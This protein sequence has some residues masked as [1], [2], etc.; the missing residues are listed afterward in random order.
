[1]KSSIVQQIAKKERGDSIKRKKPI[2]K[3]VLGNG[4]GPVILVEKEKGH[5]V[6]KKINRKTEKTKE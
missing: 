2:P 4:T 5:V 1:M 6:K 3:Y